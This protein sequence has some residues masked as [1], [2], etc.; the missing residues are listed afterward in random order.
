MFRHVLPNIAEPLILNL[1]VAVGG[2]LLA[3]PG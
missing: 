2:A 1:T 3:C